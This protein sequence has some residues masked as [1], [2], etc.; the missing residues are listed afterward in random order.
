MY[1][2]FI[3]DQHIPFHA[4]ISLYMRDPQIAFPV[5]IKRYNPSR[6]SG[7]H[8]YSG[9]LNLEQNVI[10]FSPFN[11]SHHCRICQ[12]WKITPIMVKCDRNGKSL[13]SCCVLQLCLNTKSCSL[14]QTTLITRIGEQLMDMHSV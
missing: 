7:N 2:L 9:N 1:P 5:T 12:E 14:Q 6:H 11:E 13:Q 10:A 8:M 4:A 3:F